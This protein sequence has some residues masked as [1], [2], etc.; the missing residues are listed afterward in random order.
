MRKVV[1]GVS[2]EAIANRGRL[3]YLARW[4]ANRRDFLKQARAEGYGFFARH[5]LVNLY[6]PLG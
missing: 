6:M 5:K 1:K 3:Q 4:S 2:R